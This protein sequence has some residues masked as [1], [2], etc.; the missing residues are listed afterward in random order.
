MPRKAIDLTGQR[1]GSWTVLRRSP[2]N[3]TTADGSWPM[4][5]CR[6]GC[7]KYGVVMG[8]DLRSGKSTC[9][10]KCR[11]DKRAAGLREYHRRRASEKRRMVYD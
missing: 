1:F 7:G 4:W 2:E 5:I 11:D 3:Y 8:G 9:C 6:C 10:H